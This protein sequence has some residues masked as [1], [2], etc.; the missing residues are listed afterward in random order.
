MNCQQYYWGQCEISSLAVVNGY[1]YLLGIVGLA[2]IVVIAIVIIAFGIKFQ[3]D[4]RSRIKAIEDEI[5]RKVYLEPN[6]KTKLVAFP[7]RQKLPKSNS[8]LIQLS[9]VKKDKQKEKGKDIE[10]HTNS[11]ND[12]N[13]VPDAV[14]HVSEAPE[15]EDYSGTTP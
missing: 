2:M 13:G 10:I 9:E 15:T 8:K 6:S 3:L 11:Y 12:D 14:V 4:R 7:D 5:T 1:T